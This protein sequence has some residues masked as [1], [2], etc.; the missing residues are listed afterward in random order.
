MASKLSFGRWVK[1]RRKALD[2][3]QHE[4]AHRIGC[5]LSTIQKIELDARQPSRQMATLLADHLD[6]A[7]AERD[8]FLHLAR[9]Q[10]D[11][12]PSTLSIAPHLRH[13][14]NNLPTP[15]TSLV[16]REWEVT[17]LYTHLQQAAVRLLTITGPPGV[18]KTRLA[19]AVAQML[20]GEAGV[21]HPPMQSDQPTFADG[22]CFV[23]LAPI[24][25]AALV[26][27][28][29]M[30][31]LG[32]KDLGNQPPLAQLKAFLSHKQMLLVL[33]NFEHLL[34]AAPVLADLLEAAPYLK[35]LVTSQALLQLYGEHE[36][37]TPPLVLPNL[38]ALPAPEALTSYAAVELFV[39]RARA[40]QLDFMLSTEN[41]GAVA[42]L[43]VRLDGLPLAI[44]LAA[45]RSKTL[46]PAALL[47]RLLPSTAKPGAQLNWLRSGVRNLPPRQQTLR[48]AIA[49]SYDLLNPPEQRVLRV[50][51]IFAGGCTLAALQAVVSADTAGD[52]HVRLTQGEGWLFDIVCSLVNKSLVVQVAAAK[53]TPR[54]HLLEMIREFAMEQLVAQGELPAVQR[55]HA[56]YFLT[57]AERFVGVDPQRQPPPTQAMLEAEF[58]N[59]RSAMD[60]LTSHEPTLGLHLIAYASDFWCS[61]GFYTEA[62]ARLTAALAQST[63]E[64]SY[65]YALALGRLGQI[66]WMQG[67]HTVA[68]VH[69]QQ[70][71]AL[72]RTL[73]APYELGI[74]LQFLALAL[75]NSNEYEAA[76]IPAQE[77]VALLRMQSGAHWLAIALNALG[78]I[79]SALGDYETACIIQEE[80]LTLF[81]QEQNSWGIALALIGLTDIPYAAGDFVT[82]HAYMEEALGIYRAIDDRWFTSQILWYLGKI[83]WQQGARDEA[84]AH[85]EES[86][87]VGREVGAK[88]F[89]SGSLLLLGF[90]AQQAGDHLQAQ[91]Y[92]TESLS[93][94]QQMT[95]HAGIAYALSGLA[96]L[97]EEPTKAAQLLGFTSYLLANRRM[98]LDSLERSH[99][100]R[101][102]AAVRS[103]LDEATFA[104][105]WAHGQAMSLAEAVALVQPRA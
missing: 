75:Y 77:A 101:I 84:I 105:A 63:P 98:L 94:Y 34:A 67:D 30:R 43:C 18:G 66:A 31:A 88:D 40:V 58:N 48:D 73:Q 92:F 81:R 29:I 65:P 41:A 54:F 3:T 8:A 37:V 10:P 90:A 42:E 32:L 52:S 85:W 97:S 35:L 14:I 93:L 47:A 55:A 46:A 99:Y 23:A 74:F 60:W 38:Q 56:K 62:R 21:S 45:A 24:S 9:H 83:V 15:L 22:V 91:R 79:Y 5:A 51:G 4:L 78:I 64:V 36:F 69:L 103:Q 44:E 13:S 11:H 87:A 57:L 104:A 59:L 19:L 53:E 76:L 70:S 12:E 86:I 16:G 25:E 20:A 2:M 33:D 102:V 17:T 39:Q 80:C 89:V 82:A 26:V 6:I 100:G 1:Q 95:H 68:Q 28:T 96:A 61:H 27:V 7:P 72:W 49:W 50:L 71:I